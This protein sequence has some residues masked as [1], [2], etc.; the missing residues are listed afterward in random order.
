MPEA[1]N[2]LLFTATFADKHQI[3]QNAGDRSPLNKGKNCYFDVLE[4]EKTS[5]LI[6]LVLMNDE[7]SYGVDLQDGHFEVNGVSFFQH[8]YDHPPELKD[9]R[10]IYYR[11]TRLDTH[12]GADNGIVG[13]DTI[14]SYQIGWQTNDPK[15]K[16]IK[17]IL[18]TVPVLVGSA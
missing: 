5:L 2:W 14:V 11:T 13:Q 6:S 9:F 3:I 12:V 1:K 16:N 15:G 10:H 7:T 17:R 18:K 8:R 4:Y